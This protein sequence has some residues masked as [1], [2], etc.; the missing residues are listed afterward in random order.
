M[1]GSRFGHYRI[2]RKLGEGGVGVVY[3][4]IDERLGRPVALKILLAELHARSDVVER[5]R[6]EARTLARLDHPNIATL[7]AF[8]EIEGSLVMV[9]EFVEGMTLASLVQ[10]AGRLAP[11]HALPIFLQALDGIGHAHSLG[12]VHR[13]I[14]GS[15]VMLD[16]RG[17]LKVM[18]FGIARTLG[19]ARHTQLG[20]VVGTPEFMAPEQI[21]GDDTDA[22]ADVYSL[23]I[24]LFLLLTGR[25]P[26]VGGS[27]FEL[28]RA[29]VEE[30]PPRLRELAPDLPEALEA[31]VDRALAKHPDERIASCD[32]FRR[33]LAPFTPAAQE[34][35]RSPSP[36]DVLSRPDW[37]EVDE[38][39]PSAEP[40]GQ[41][42]VLGMPR[43]SSEA[44]THR[45]P[46]PA[47]GGPWRR[48]LAWVAGLGTLALVNVLWW[49]RPISPAGPAPDPLHAAA[50]PVPVTAGAGV[51]SAAPVAGKG[52][53]GDPAVARDAESGGLAPDAAEPDGGP[54]ARTDAA[55]RTERAQDGPAAPGRAPAATATAERASPTKRRVSRPERPRPARAVRRPAP[56]PPAQEPEPEPK[57]E[58]VEGWII[59]RD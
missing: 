18:D 49:G 14:K 13:D 48:P 31:V 1:I 7:H 47:A 28:M 20:H 44:P 29:Q 32:D 33:A 26:F 5:F 36:V 38:P 9:M 16:T 56:R 39:I 53:E 59:R 35:A 15:N 57:E 22:R 54:V 23:G 55:Q 25:T 40:A 21:R 58:T 19:S 2:D 12:I 8:E 52:G 43:P 11:E 6:A 30:T 37:D 4:A 17:L 42:A 41:T 51:D 10:G 27:G 34:A 45:H 24:L 46:A 3:R 50:E